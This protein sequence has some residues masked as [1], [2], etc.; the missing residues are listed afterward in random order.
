MRLG[1]CTLGIAIALT[2]VRAAL[3]GSPEAADAASPRSPPPSGPAEATPAAGPAEGDAP[4]VT[5]AREAFKLG[6]ALAKQG[7]WV[8]ALVAFQRSSDLKAHPI[9]MYNVAYCER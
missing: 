3:A 2:C 7:Q 9:T 5:E 1:T 8:D 4:D 6:A